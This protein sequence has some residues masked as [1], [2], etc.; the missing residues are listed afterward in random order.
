MFATSKPQN[1]N[2]IVTPKYQIFYIFATL[3][4]HYGNSNTKIRSKNT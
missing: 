3:M 4:S 2:N 1:I